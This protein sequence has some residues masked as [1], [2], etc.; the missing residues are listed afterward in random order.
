MKVP[1]LRNFQLIFFTLIIVPI[2][3]ALPCHYVIYWWRD[4]AMELTKN[5]DGYAD[6]V[7]IFFYRNQYAINSSSTIH[8][9][10]I[11]QSRLHELTIPNLMYE[12]TYRIWMMSRFGCKKNGTENKTEIRY[13]I[14]RYCKV[15]GDPSINCRAYFSLD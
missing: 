3:S 12:N 9:N 1:T 2:F 14:P 6:N 7:P 8:F 4:Q 13:N 11:W 10:E 15:S 5:Y